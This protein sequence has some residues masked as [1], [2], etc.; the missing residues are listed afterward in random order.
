VRPPS[1]LFH[2][3]FT[4]GGCHKRSRGTIDMTQALRVRAPV[5]IVKREME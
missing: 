3:A 1:G 5:L 2:L 4:L